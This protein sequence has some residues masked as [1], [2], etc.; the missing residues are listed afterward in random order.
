MWP[1]WSWCPACGSA[2]GTDYAVCARCGLLLT[3]NLPVGTYGRRDLLGITDGAHPLSHRR[4]R[5]GLLASLWACVL[6]WIPTVSLFGGLLLSAGSYFLHKDRARFGHRHALSTRAAFAL[7]WVAFLL[8]AVAFGALLWYGN[9]AYL[10]HVRLD[11]IRGLLLAFVLVTTVPTVLLAV[12]LA[13][14]VKELLPGRRVT[15]WLA[16]ALL[17]ALVVGATVMAYLEIATGLP[18]APIRIATV[19]GVLNRVALW[20]MVEAPG[21]FAFAWLYRSAL[22]TTA[23]GQGVAV[24]G[25]RLIL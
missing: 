7:L 14:Q 23:A 24:T 15:V 8:Y 2:L 25:P 1:G 9:E 17:I 21:F 13:L 18:D 6:L 5:W 12:S 19:L 10:G 11:G 4:T 22:R 20:R 16:S 3:A